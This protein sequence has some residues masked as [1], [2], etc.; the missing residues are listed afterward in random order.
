[1]PDQRDA[2]TVLEVSRAAS[3]L[4]VR[5]AYW[6]LA[7]RYHPDGSAPDVVRMT[8]VN[9]AYEEIER[10]RRLTG[11]EAPAPVPTGPGQST[12][13]GATSTPSPERGEPPAGSLL[14]RMRR[15]EQGESAVL[16]FGEYAGRRIADVAKVDPRY[17]RWLARQVSG[18]R[19]RTE[20]ERV[21]GRDW[22][23]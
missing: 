22:E 3:T 2:Y 7:R 10:E 15:A 16:D 14:H 20:I 12:G 5:A 19:Y 4:V 9:A 23:I 8:E 18:V 13:A 6:K 1:M 17:L 21:I 11:R